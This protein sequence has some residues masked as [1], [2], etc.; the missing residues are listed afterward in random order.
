LMLAEN[1]RSQTLYLCNWNELCWIFY[2]NMIVQG[3]W[4]KSPA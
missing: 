1:R 2:T 4:A 3:I